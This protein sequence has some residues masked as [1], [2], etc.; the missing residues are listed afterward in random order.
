M[1]GIPPLPRSYGIGDPAIHVPSPTATVA[2]F[3][4][5]SDLHVLMSGELPFVGGSIAHKLFAQSRNE[6]GLV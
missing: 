6:L 5:V 1:P 2:G 3:Q 4:T